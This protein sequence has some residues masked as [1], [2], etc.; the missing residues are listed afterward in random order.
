LRQ[1]Y[2]TDNPAEP[3]KQ[4]LADRVLGAGESVRLY[5]EN[6]RNYDA[7]GGAA[8]AFN[9]KDGETLTIS[10]REGETVFALELPKLAAG[11]V[12]VR[13]ER[14]GRYENYYKTS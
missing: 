10:D 5:C 3:E 7:L 9:L 4:V 6:Y 14:N 13:N 8:L 2:I 12:L 1:Y 11:Y